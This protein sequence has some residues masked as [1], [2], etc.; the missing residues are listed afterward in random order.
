MD[1]EQQ[2]MHLAILQSLWEGIVVVDNEQAIRFINPVACRLLGIDAGSALG[3]HFTTL[4]SLTMFKDS[5][6][7]AESNETARDPHFPY[8]QR[9][10]ITMEDGHTL[11]LQVGPIT[12]SKQQ[13]R[14]GTLIRVGERTHEF[15]ACDLLEVVLHELRTPLKFIEG[16]AKLLLKKDLGSLTEKQHEAVTAIVGR[17]EDLLQMQL[18]IFDTYLKKKEDVANRITPE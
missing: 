12:D 10:L 2:I 15:T 1:E 4:S 14:I 5:D 16:W 13:Q 8:D 6:W 11:E 9:R 17:V 3:N 18:E 7:L